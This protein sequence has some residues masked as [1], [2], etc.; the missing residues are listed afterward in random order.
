[1]SNFN[2]LGSKVRN[3]IRERDN[4]ALFSSISGC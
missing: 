1:M 3:A 2:Y 4:W